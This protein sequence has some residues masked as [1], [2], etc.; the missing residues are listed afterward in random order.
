MAEGVG[1]LTMNAIDP[2]TEGAVRTFLGRLPP[3]LPLE[4]ALL[5]G[6]RARGDFGPESD[7]DVALVVAHAA[8]HWRTLWMLGGLAYDVYLETDVL[9]QP[10]LV[11]SQDWAQPARFRRPSF[12]MNVAAEGIPL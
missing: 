10:V 2:A 9:I 6:S 11:S 12:L 8:N 3:D 1:L 4:R 7:A 5:F